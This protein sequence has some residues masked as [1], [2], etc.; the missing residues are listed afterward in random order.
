MKN[1]VAA[2]VASIPGILA[3]LALWNALAICLLVIYWVG[4]V[5]LYLGVLCGR[6]KFGLGLCTPP[7]PAVQQII[8]EWSF[9]FTVFAFTWG[10]V[11][12]VAGRPA[13]AHAAIEESAR[14]YAQK[15][16]LPALDRARKRADDLVATRSRSQ[17]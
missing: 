4:Y 17:G 16:N 1:L 5:V 13:D 9:F 15:G 10:E 7:D 14:R 2:I 3:G 8:N 12:A 6:G 11:L